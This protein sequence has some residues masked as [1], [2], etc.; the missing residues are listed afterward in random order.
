MLAWT[1]RDPDDADVLLEEARPLWRKIGFKQGVG[2]TLLVM[3][4]VAWQ[5]GDAAQ[6]TR[7]CD[8]ALP[9]FQVIRRLACFLS[10]HR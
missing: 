8:E 3:A 6:A 1:Q 10:T 5:R 2:R 7:R 9:L 4:L